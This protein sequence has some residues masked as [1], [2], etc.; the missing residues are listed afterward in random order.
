MILRDNGHKRKTMIS[1]HWELI[2]KLNR[3]TIW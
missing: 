2:Y 1:P 3:L